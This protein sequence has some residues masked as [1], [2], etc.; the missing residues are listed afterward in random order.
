MFTD[1]WTRDNRFISSDAVAWGAAIVRI[2]GLDNKL[3]PFLF[4]LILK[5][6]LVQPGYVDCSVAVV[7]GFAMSWISSFSVRAFRPFSNITWQRASGLGTKWGNRAT[8]LRQ[9]R[10][11]EIQYVAVYRAK[12]SLE[13]NDFIFCILEF[14]PIEIPIYSPQIFVK[15]VPL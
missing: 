7:N 8:Y 6:F 3:C 10:I 5:L 1:D 2:N 15:Y 12:L 4:E 14:D 13:K 11:T 9:F